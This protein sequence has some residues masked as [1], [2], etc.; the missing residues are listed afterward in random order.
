MIISDAVVKVEAEVKE[1]PKSRAWKSTISIEDV[2]EREDLT[3]YQYKYLVTYED[4]KVGK[5][6]IEG[7]LYGKDEPKEAL[8][9]WK[10][11]K[12]LPAKELERLL[13]IINY[14]GPAHATIVARVINF[15]PPIPVPTIRIPGAEAQQAAT[16]QQPSPKKDVKSAKAEQEKEK[17]ADKKQQKKSK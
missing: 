13:S 5:I 4:G 11:E 10:K 12:K 14:I 7:E 6:S 8:E 17:S 2:K 1:R 15:P 9:L 3:V 16:S